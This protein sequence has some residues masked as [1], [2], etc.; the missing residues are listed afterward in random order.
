MEGIKRLLF[1]AAGVCYT[2]QSQGAILDLLHIEPSNESLDY[3]K[4]KGQYQVSALATEGQH[5][6][7]KNL[8]FQLR[9]DTSKGLEALFSV[10]EELSGYLLKFA[11]D[12]ALHQAVNAI[13]NA[14]LG[15]KKI[16]IC[17]FGSSGRLATQLERNVWRP[18]WARL[19]QHRA[20]GKKLKGPWSNNIQERLVG[21]MVGFNL[22]AAIAGVEDV[23]EIGGVQLKEY[24]IQKGDVVFAITSS[25]G[26][27]CVL[28]SLLAAAEIYN[29]ERQKPI[30]P[31]QRSKDKLYFTHNNLNE[32]LLNFERS[33]KII[34]SDAITT[35]SLHTGPQAIAGS[36]R[37]Q[38][39]TVDTFVLG[40]IIEQ[41]ISNVLKRFLS[42]EEM[43]VLGFKANLGLN[44]RFSSFSA[45]PQ[46]MFQVKDAIASLT[47]RETETYRQK[48]FATYFAGEAAMVMFTDAGERSPTFHL[49]PLDK[50]NEPQRKCWIQVW[51]STRK[52]KEA[53][54]H[55]FGQGDREKTL[56]VYQKTYPYFTDLKL[57]EIGLSAIKNAAE[58]KKVDYD[59]SFSKVNAEKNGPQKGGFGLMVL[60]TQDLPLLQKQGSLFQEWLDLFAKAES[61]IAVMVMTKKTLPQNHEAI[62]IIS[63]LAPEAHLLQIPSPG[64][65]PLGIGEQVLLKMILNAH[66]TAIMGKLGRF[67]GNAMVNVRPVNLKLIGRATYLIQSF[68][69]TYLARL[70]LQE[71]KG[72]QVSYAEANAILYDAM[73]NKRPEDTFS[74]VTLSIV[75]SLEALK[76]NKFVSWDN[77]RSLL[78]IKSLED[79]LN[80]L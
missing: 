59:F 77:A 64:N 42:E 66:S 22:P 11:K 48:K 69:N 7:T 70:D 2:L 20:I 4:N 58:F 19:Q 73:A 27:S 55:L 15:N 13:E 32:V 62:E 33:R 24:G 18:F 57:K 23:L 68:I 41:A 3:V 61:T 76:Q 71:R 9:K 37:M 60:T 52:A 36:T 12:P 29:N 21:T 30:V 39:A 53:W 35:I 51:T 1:T 50:W 74:E 8:S 6:K 31:G 25:D 54:E 38:A 45:L 65:D 14:I 63:A 10:D 43:N 34:E 5:P 80:S 26:N 40:M 28:G 79:Y 46:T 16:Y 17:G 49:A 75:R 78:K 44:E 47:D 56:H 67:V 72:Y